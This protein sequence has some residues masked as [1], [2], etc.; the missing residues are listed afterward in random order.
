MVIY[1]IGGY[2]RMYPKKH[3]KDEAFWRRN[4]VILI[5]IDLLSI[6]AGTWVGVQIGKRGSYFFVS[7]SNTFASGTTRNSWYVSL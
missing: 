5:I 3:S 7:D 4:S 2:L 1:F 6:F